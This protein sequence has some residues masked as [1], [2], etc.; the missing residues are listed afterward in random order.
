MRY[1]M[2]SIIIILGCVIL[3]GLAK[4]RLLTKPLRIPLKKKNY[5][6]SSSE[7]FNLTFAQQVHRRTMRKYHVGNSALTL[8]DEA[9][10]HKPVRIGRKTLKTRQA[11]RLTDQGDQRKG[12]LQIG[13]HRQTF[14]V[15]FDT[16]SADFWV[17]SSD[18][19]LQACASKNVYNASA[20]NTSSLKTGDFNLAYGDG[21]STAGKPYSDSVS[22]AGITIL[23]QTFA[24]ATVLADSLG[25]SP[26]DGILGLAYPI[27]SHLKAP[28]VMENA[29]SQGLIPS[30]TFSLDLSSDAG[31][32]FLGGV[33]QSK[34]KGELEIHPVTRPAYWQLGGSA[35]H[36]NAQQISHANFQTILDSGTSIIY[37][38]AAVVDGI[39][40]Q[41]NGSS[42]VREDEGFWKF[43]CLNPPL[44]SFSWGNGTRWEIS[45]EKI[46]LGKIKENETECI[47][48][49]SSH[50][51]HKKFD[52]TW[53]LGDT[54]MMN[55]Y[56][57]F[58]PDANTIGFG[59]LI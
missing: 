12:L 29:F 9:G 38:P 40:A 27:I 14:T 52:E 11:E 45:P 8:M 46:S 18:C 3:E 44:V 5:V 49:I 13:T 6:K 59:E 39:Y 55:V 48:A 22:L 42:R 7:V 2:F 21:S 19:T 56:S 43:P 58:D 1:I 53:L 30:K 28:S 24:S 20:S 23:N 36:V 26:T 54:F 34:F 4:E 32:F 16:G 17:P 31:E 41:V 33:D 35:V 47:G 50:T 57:V 10:K 37:G 25:K 15:D 51:L